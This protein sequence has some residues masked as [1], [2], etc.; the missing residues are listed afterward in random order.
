MSVFS[1]KVLAMVSMV[2][3][4]LGWW[5]ELEGIIGPGLCTAMRAFGRMAFPIFAFLIVNGYKH[6][7]DK[8]SYLTRLMAFAL[9]SQIPYVLVFSVENY[10]DAELGALSLSLPGAVQIV[11]CIA[12][13]ILWYL[14]VRRDFTALLPG[15]ALLIGLSTLKI[16]TVYI[17]RPDMNVFYTLGFS[18]A[19]MCVLDK[20]RERKSESY[21][22]C[23]SLIIAL[24]LIWDRADYGID[25]IVLMLALWYFAPNKTQQLLMMLIWSAAHYMPGLNPIYYFLCAAAA[26]LPVYL[27]NGRLGKALKTV[28]YLVYPLHLSVMAAIIM[29][30]ARL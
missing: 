4:H 19:A 16:G 22:L 25:G 20:L 5:L 10:F 28:F 2:C 12:L 17:L 9:I 1:L 27:Y 6:S 18:L 26:L 24:I 29:W 21:M 8:V 11:L 30:Q 14:L 23:L 3:D 13:S 15:L 7:R